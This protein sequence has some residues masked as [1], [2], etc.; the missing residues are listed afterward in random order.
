[1]LQINVAEFNETHI[2]CYKPIL[3]DKLFFFSES[4]WSSN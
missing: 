3:C 2:L 4:W 1:M